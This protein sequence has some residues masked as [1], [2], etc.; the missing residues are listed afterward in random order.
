LLGIPVNTGIDPT[1]A[2]VVGARI[3]AQVGRL[4]PPSS[5]PASSTATAEVDVSKTIVHGS[6]DEI[7]IIVVEGPSENHFTAKNWYRKD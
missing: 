7:R 2:I 1:N 3:R 4:F 5:L 6:E